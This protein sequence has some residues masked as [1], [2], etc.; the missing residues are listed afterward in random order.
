MATKKAGGST[1]LGR[2][3][4]SQRLGVKRFGGEKILAGNIIVRQKGNKFFPGRNVGQGKD[5]TLYA[6]I[7]GVVSFQE[8]KLKKFNNRVYKDIFVNI[9]KDD[10]VK[11]KKSTIKKEKKQEVVQE[12]KKEEEV[13]MDTKE[14]EKKETSKKKTVTKKASTTTK[15]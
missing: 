2:D 7:D 6:L 12:V 4:Q 13:K 1:R 11:T 8:K 15:K 5:F 3:S 10:S 14:V 9:D